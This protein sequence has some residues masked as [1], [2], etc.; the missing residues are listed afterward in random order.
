MLAKTTGATP[1]RLVTHMGDVGHTLIV[2]PTGA[3]KSVLLALMALQFRRYRDSQVYIFDKG[4]SARAATLA[5]GGHFYDLGEDSEL[6]FQPLADIDENAARSWASEWIAGLL[7]HEKVVVT[8]EVKEAVWSALTNLSGAPR[9]ER[10]LTGLSVLMQSNA[11]KQALHPYTLEGPFGRLL[12]AD[13]DRLE[14]APVQCFE[15]EDLMHEASLVPPV[16]TY[17]F[18]RLEARFDG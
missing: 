5:M 8:P 9:E 10:T 16:L 12:D 3:G 6:A 1:F 11:L 13:E 18:H 2:G 7:T 4:G 14:L 15:M 17:L